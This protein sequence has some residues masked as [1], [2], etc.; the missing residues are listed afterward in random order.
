MNEGVVAVV[1]AGVADE[2]AGRRAVRE[3]SGPWDSME[4]LG[5]EGDCAYPNRAT[6]PQL[7]THTQHTEAQ[8]FDFGFLSPLN[9][10]AHSSY[11][12]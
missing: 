4:S 8:R 10:E 5:G 1:A 9:L 12:R 3:C 6:L 11:S 2:A 7:H